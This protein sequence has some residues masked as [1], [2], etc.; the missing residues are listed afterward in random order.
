MTEAGYT[1]E[2]SDKIKL[3]KENEELLGT[4]I[5]LLSAQNIHVTDV[6]HLTNDLNLLLEILDSVKGEEEK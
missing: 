4:A 2:D 3:L 6:Q 5:Q 1:L